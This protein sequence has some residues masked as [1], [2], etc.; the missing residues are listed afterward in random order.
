[1]RL[2]RIDEF[3]RH[4][5]NCVGDRYYHVNKPALVMAASVVTERRML[6]RPRLKR[7]SLA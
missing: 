7:P 4:E 1:M 2:A 5:R 6:A 3:G